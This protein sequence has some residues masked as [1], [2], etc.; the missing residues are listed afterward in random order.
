LK[1]RYATITIRENAYRNSLADGVPYKK[2]LAKKKAKKKAAQVEEEEAGE[3]FIV[4][5]LLETRR[6]NGA[7]EFL[8]KWWGY[9]AEADRTWEGTG[10][11]NDALDSYEG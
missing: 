5:K 1:R 11:L 8:V 9:D 7:R 3:E 10:N 6:V 2:A 4:E